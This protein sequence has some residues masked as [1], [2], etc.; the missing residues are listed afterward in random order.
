MIIKGLKWLL[1]IPST[2]VREQNKLIRETEEKN[3]WQNAM[4]IT[5]KKIINKIKKPNEKGLRYDLYI[6]IGDK[7]LDLKEDEDFN[8]FKKYLIKETDNEIY[9]MYKVNLIKC[10]LDWD[11][12]DLLHKKKNGE[13]HGVKQEKM[14]EENFNLMFKIFSDQY[15]YQKEKLEQQIKRFEYKFDLKN[16]KINFIRRND[17]IDNEKKLN[18][19]N[20]RLK[21]LE[22]E[23]QIS[24]L[25]KIAKNKDFEF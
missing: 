20:A 5:F 7:N 18:N 25:E 15:N 16:S 6:K 11:F 23:Q 17:K 2:E 12:D 13:I 24:E 14:S 9:E 21:I 4:F 3:R 1:G 8:I 10:E 19:T 22:L